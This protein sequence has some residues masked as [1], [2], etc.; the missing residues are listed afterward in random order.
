MSSTKERIVFIQDWIY[1][2]NRSD[3]LT[4]FTG[5][6]AQ[7]RISSAERIESA[8]LHT[9]RSFLSQ[10]KERCLTPKRRDALIKA[11]GTKTFDAILANPSSLDIIKAE[12]AIKH[13]IYRAIT[14]KRDFAV[15]LAFLTKRKWDCRWAIP[16]YEKYKDETILQLRRDPYL[17][18]QHDLTSFKAADWVFLNDGGTA[19]CW[20]PCSEKQNRM[21]V[22]LYPGKSCVRRSR[23][24]CGIPTQTLRHPTAP[25][26]RPISQKHSTGWRNVE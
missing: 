22:H 10:I 7:W 2:I 8:L 25:Y 4:V 12:P 9:I 18:Y 14:E 19:L 6:E 24:C 13:R 1:R 17:L 15:L 21:G 5:K 11:Y 16:L 3:K 26:P 23:P 20:R